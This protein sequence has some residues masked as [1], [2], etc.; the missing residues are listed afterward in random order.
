MRK[1]L[2]IKSSNFFYAE[3][4]GNQIFRLLMRKKLE[5][6][7]SNFF[8]TPLVVRVTHLLLK[9]FFAI[10]V[11]EW[12]SFAS[13]VSKLRVQVEE[14][15]VS[16]L[17]QEDEVLG[18]KRELDDLRKEETTLEATLLDLAKRMERVTDCYDKTQDQISEVRGTANWVC[19]YA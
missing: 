8:D 12:R 10:Y 17:E 4:V 15:E 19:E 7:S 9:C 16:L 2:E 13:Q 18:K 6:K 3:K 14:Q 1:K 11:A 5:I